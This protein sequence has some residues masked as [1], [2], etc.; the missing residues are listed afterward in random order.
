MVALR[1]TTTLV[2]FL[3]WT[4]LLLPLQILALR[5]GSPLMESI[6]ML[7][8]RGVAR[9]MRIHVRRIGEIS[10]ERPTLFVVNHIS[11]I[12]IIVLDTQIKAS[13]IAKHEIASWPLFGLLAKLQRSVFI[14]RKARR[15][16]DH[17]DE[18]TVRLDAGDSLILF[19]EGTSS[20][21]L[22]VQPFKS[23]FFVLAERQVRNRP[24]LVQPVTI[25]YSRLNNMPVGRRWMPIFAWVGDENL[26]PHLW[27]FVK[28]GPAECVV[29]FHPPVTID[30]FASRKELAAY[31][32]R[33]IALGVSDINS[34]RPSP[35][36]AI[37]QKRPAPAPEGA[38]L[39]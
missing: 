32:H 28:N 11:W 3:L 15:T 19:P 17:R 29:E 7:Y 21:G 13:F 34:G 35:R 26:A 18:M 22:R 38:P 4:L 39:A 36:P 23:A 24:L 27:R 6:P 9:L 5:L 14:E 30:Q 33:L 12:D 8:H 20:D 16:A 1:A 2:L 37:P 31:C 10:T 25:G